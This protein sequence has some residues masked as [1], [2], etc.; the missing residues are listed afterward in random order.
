MS[1]IVDTLQA[2]IDAVFEA[3]PETMRGHI[4]PS[5]AGEP[6]DRRLWLGFRW[7]I[8]KSFPGRVLRLF[9]RGQDEE[10]RVV[11]WLHAIGVDVRESGDSQRRVNFGGHISGSID[12]IILGGVPE[13]P[14][15]EHILEI[16]TH[17]KKSFD[18][19]SGKGVKVSKPEH[20]I[21]M[22][23]YMEA[24]GIDRAL[25]VAV[26]KDDDRIYHE[27]VEADGIAARVAIDR[28]KRIA[29]TEFIPEPISNDPTWY[30]CRFCEAHDFCHKKRQTKEVNCRTCA[31]ATALA[32]GAWHCARWGSE[33]PEDAQREGCSSHVPHPDLVPWKLD[34]DRSTEIAGYYDGVGL[35]G[36]GGVSSREVLNV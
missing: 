10:A 36:E 35:I 12:G 15:T 6:C 5:Q 18:T 31:H 22:Q 33:I 25:Y 30:Q 20:W 29:R 34:R 11:S 14:K 23:C 1:E 3:M 4:G 19:V 7:A 13:A 8:R 21:Q 28:L 24:T 9:R 16:K 17:N 32:S 2:K 26:C 27:R